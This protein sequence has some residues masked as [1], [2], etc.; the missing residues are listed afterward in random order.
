MSSVNRG[1][2]NTEQGNA[3]F[4]NMIATT[5]NDFRDMT[6]A[7]LDPLPSGVGNGTFSQG[8]IML[9]DLGKTVRIPGN[10]STSNNNQQRILR[11]VQRVDVAAQS[12]VNSD[13]FINYNEGVGGKADDGING[14]ETFYIDLIGTGAPKWVRISV[15]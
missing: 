10:R 2:K 1:L 7:P 6:G 11:L 8:A 15:S 12:L 14:F 4:I 5:S 9:R 3:Y 13:S